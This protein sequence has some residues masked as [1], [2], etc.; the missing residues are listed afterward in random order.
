MVMWIKFK[1]AIIEYN[2]S[3]YRFYMNLNDI[4]RARRLSETNE[5]PNVINDM[6][7]ET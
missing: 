6:S 3:I 5:Q 4:F 7:I 2:K 1:K